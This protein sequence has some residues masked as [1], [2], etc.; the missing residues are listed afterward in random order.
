MQKKL[1]VIYGILLSVLTLVVG[2]G[3]IYK[4]INQDTSI[5]KREINTDEYYSLRNNATVYQK[6]IYKNLIEA[7]ETN[8]KSEEAVSLLAQNFVADFYTWTN[9]HRLND[10][11]GIQF[12]LE[13]LKTDAYKSAQD[14][15]YQDVLYYV[16]NETIQNTLE[17]ESVNIKSLEKIQFFIH[18]EES[19]EEHFNEET[20]ENMKGYYVDAYELS[21]NWTYID[22]GFDT[23]KYEK[24]ANLIIIQ[25]DLPY[26]VEVN[27][28][29]EI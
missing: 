5:P 19:E 28:D 1:F 20:W 10:V 6:E 16:E 18:D 27:H 25:E 11:G 12:V 8:A 24:S 15:I 17:V 26:I 9:K 14:T 13:D 7:I 4:T 3:F 22:N 29:E 2:G 21:V 23:S